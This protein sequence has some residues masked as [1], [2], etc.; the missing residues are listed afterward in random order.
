MK[1]KYIFASILAT[2]ALA[3]SCEKEADHYLA[4]LKLSTSYVALPV[5]GGAVTVTYTATDAVSV[6]ETPEWLTV[7][8]ATGTTSGE[9][10]LRFEATAGEG[11]TAEVILTCAGKTQRVNVIQGLATVSTA[12]CAEVIAGPDSKTY[13]VTGVVTKIV[14]TTY[15]N[16]YLQDDTGEIYIYG[17]LDSKG[18]TKNFLSWGL[19]VGDEIT[20]EGPKT[21]YN[22]TVE[23][24]DVTVIKINKSLIKVESTDPEDRVLPLEGGDLVVTLA[25]KG[26]NLGVEIPEDVKSWL[27]ITAL[28][29]NVVTLTAAPNAGGDREATVTFKTTDGEK[30]YTASLS[31]SQKGAIVEITAAEFNQLEDGT[32]LYKIKGVITSI[33]MDKSDASKYNKYGN[34]YIQDG[35]GSV[36]VYGLLPEAGGASGQDVLT[37]MGAKVGDVITVVGPKGSYK[38]NPQMVNAY[39]DGFTSVTAATAAEFNALADGSDLYLISGKITSIVMDKSDATKYN[40]YGNF[41]VEDATGSVYVYGL[42]PSSTG[43]SGQD[44]LTKLGVK[45]GDEIT[46]VGPKS[47]YKSNPQMVNGFY[48]S[49]QEGVAE[50]EG[51]EEEGG[52]EEGGEEGDTNAYAS[53]VTWSNLTSA[54]DDGVATVNGVADVK[55]LKFGTSSKNGSAVITIPAGATEVSFYA[56]GWKAKESMMTVKN[57]E[58]TLKEISVVANEGATGNAP[59][60]IT[61]AD[62]DKYVVSFESALAAETALTF[63][64]T[65][66]VILFAI[67]AK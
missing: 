38:G 1:L 62:T 47:S 31:L 49:H 54:Y 60:T 19:E 27:S 45:V 21:T 33:V 36:Y 15:G 13:R 29:G 51:G 12:T 39:S 42:V 37:T 20:V 4:E 26:E 8:T 56:V 57:G 59:Y 22:G 52:E 6:G 28:D 10:A 43:A 63:E 14:N 23:L 24:V 7:S 50:E 61:V 55:T 58:T 46:L 65:G 16:W 9:G 32:A 11:R 44:L 18:G 53:N 30:D 40:K 66:R 2:L 25:N 48:V 5:E 35:T 41:Y 34:F 3:V 17:T 67:V 64:S